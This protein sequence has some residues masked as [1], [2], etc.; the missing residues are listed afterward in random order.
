MPENAFHAPDTARFRADSLML[1]ARNSQNERH[2]SHDGRRTQSTVCPGGRAERSG[3]GFARVT[4]TSGRVVRGGVRWKGGRPAG[5]TLSTRAPAAASWSKRR[6]GLRCWV[7]LIRPMHLVCL[8]PSS[9]TGADEQPAHGDRDETPQQ[10]R[11]GNAT[12]H[13]RN[14]II[15]QRGGADKQCGRQDAKN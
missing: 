1:V 14:L 5:H 3:L 9:P 8:L 12:D 2:A 11:Q 4:R 13:R 6:V 10:S 7:S 15:T